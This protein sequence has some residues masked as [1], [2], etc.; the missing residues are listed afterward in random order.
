[1]R[2]GCARLPG[3]WGCSSA[4]RAP[5][6]HRGGQGFESPHLHQPPCTFPPPTWRH[7]DPGVTPRVRSATRGPS[8]SASANA[9]AIEARR[10]RL[11]DRRP[12]PAPA[13][14]RGAGRPAPKA[15]RRSSPGCGLWTTPE[16]LGAPPGGPE[17]G[18]VSTVENSS[19]K[20]CCGRENAGRSVSTI[21]EGSVEPPIVAR[22]D[23]HRQDE[24]LLSHSRE[25]RAG[26]ERQHQ[27]S[28]RRSTA[29]VGAPGKRGHC[30]PIHAQR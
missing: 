12:A 19:E 16:W 18:I 7:P 14:A 27:R 5:R 13:R 24:H 26:V 20:R 30:P 6:S 15:D 22:E 28:S 1:M 10:D 4:G 3:A 29:A 17:G 25:D 23:D 21:D 9:F 8:D 2:L 11:C